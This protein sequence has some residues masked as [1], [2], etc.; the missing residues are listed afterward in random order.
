MGLSVTILAL[1]VTGL[2]LAAVAAAMVR[3]FRAASEGA[4]W[5]A[6]PRRWLAGRA[7]YAGAA[8]AVLSSWGIAASLLL[9]VPPIGG[10]EAVWFGV[11]GLAVA[12][13]PLGVG[14][15]IVV[16]AAMEA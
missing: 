5:G 13:V 3:L 14:L 11:V 6:A 9:D 12:A 4:A 1:V 8:L 2:G 16:D 10:V 15:T 7:F